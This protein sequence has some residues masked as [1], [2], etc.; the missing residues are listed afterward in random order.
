VLISAGNPRARRC[1][2]EVDVR[3]TGGFRS[4]RSLNTP[5]TLSLI[6][7]GM[8]LNSDQTDGYVIGIEQ[9]GDGF[10]EGSFTFTVAEE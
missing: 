8:G 2:F 9:N 7:S 6:R 10:T 4:L 3:R 1:N 5:Y